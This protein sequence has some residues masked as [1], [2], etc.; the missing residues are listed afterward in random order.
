MNK[1]L[2]DLIIGYATSKHAEVSTNLLNKSKDNIIAILMDLLAN[3]FNDK[4]S[5]SLRENVIVTLSGFEVIGTKLGYNGYR[6][7]SIGG[8]ALYCEAKPRN[9]NTNDNK[10]KKLDGGSNFSDYTW[11]RFE[12]DKIANPVM[13]IGG[14][15]DGKL[16]Y[17]F[18]FPFETQSFTDRLEERLTNRFPDGDISQEYLRS[19][20]F[21]LVDYQS[22]LTKQS[23]KLFVDKGTLQDM[24]QHFTGKLYSVLEEYVDG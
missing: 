23:V 13:I 9:I 19:A 17:V 14:F 22:A 24:K 7:N 4:N 3:Y 18:R 6:Q 11:K 21:R 16:I 10:L 8:E 1:D 15:V 20:Q 5:S 12:K 2:Q